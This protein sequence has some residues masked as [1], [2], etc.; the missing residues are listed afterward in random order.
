[1]GRLHVDCPRKMCR[2]HCL[3]AG[4]C[5]VKTH[6]ASNVIAGASLPL[7]LGGQER[8]LSS[9]PPP[10]NPPRSVAHSVNLAPAGPSTTVGPAL[11]FF[12][13]PCHASQIVP[14]FTHQYAR[15]Q[16]FEESK[17]AADAERLANIEKAKH[18]VMVYGWA[19]VSLS[20]LLLLATF[21]ILLSQD[22]KDATIFEAQG[23]FKWPHFVL[24][25]E[26]LGEVD[27]L[28]GAED[29]VRV[30]MYNVSIGR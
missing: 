12:A 26:V 5:R 22:D 1:M 17:R 25:A 9:S 18:S 27:L 24:S 14:A 28:V 2:R 6:L 3:E 13:N 15:E 20:F 11:D 29:E 8:L 16:A 19:R 23:G 7:A 4:G 30:D 21:K 10:S